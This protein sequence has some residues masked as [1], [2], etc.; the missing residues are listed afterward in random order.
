M[1]KNLSPTSE[2]L[3]MTSTNSSTTI[4][5]IIFYVWLTV[6]V[7]LYQLDALILYSNTFIILLYTFRAILCSSSGH[8]VLVQH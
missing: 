5:F 1:I 2:L 6:I 4:N 3:N 8:I 7:F